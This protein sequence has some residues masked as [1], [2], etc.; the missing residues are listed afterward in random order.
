MCGEKVGIW[1]RNNQATLQFYNKNVEAQFIASHRGSHNITI[2]NGYIA[3]ISF[4]KKTS[5]VTCI[6]AGKLHKQFLTL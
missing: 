4:W 2:Q 6:G 5:F 1:L 3:R